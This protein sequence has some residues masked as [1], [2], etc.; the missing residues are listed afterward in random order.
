MKMGKSYVF[1]ETDASVG[2]IASRSVVKGGSVVSAKHCGPAEPGH[3][4]EI[5]EVVKTG[6]RRKTRRNTRRNRK[7]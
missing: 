1:Q 3:L 6:G 2:R 5:L 4:Y 7:H